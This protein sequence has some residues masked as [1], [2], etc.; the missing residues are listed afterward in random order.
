[1]E[2]QQVRY[3]L[4]L[5]GTRNFTRAAEQCH[6]SQPALTRAI[7][8]LEDELGGELIRREGRLSHLT[9]LGRRMEPLLRQCYEGATQAKALA[10]AVQAGD[11]ATLTLAISHT[12]AV[13]LLLGV[14][15]ELYRAF[16]SL[17]LKIRRGSAAEIARL[18]KDGD[19]DIAVA[20]PLGETWDRLES[21]P[22][23]TEAYE[24]VLGAGHPLALRNEP[25]ADLEHLRGERFLVQVGGEMAEAQRDRLSAQGLALDHAHEV[26]TDRDLAALLEAGLGVAV[27][28]S[29]A[30]RSPGLRRL[31]FPALD[32][33]RTV[34]VYAAAG[35]KR[36]AEAATLLNMMRTTDWGA[37]LAAE[38]M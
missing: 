2:M 16:P 27:A 32:L 28:P 35:R 23:F 14:I 17:Q 36:T 25:A 15:S 31:A 12:V 6:V 34:C 8:A 38:E 19:V 21:W 29:S 3:F 7:Q 18:L 22:M 24:L 10:R 13:E 26:E 1:M 9:E 5:A 4:A 33:H 30:P 11:L 20:G 37:R